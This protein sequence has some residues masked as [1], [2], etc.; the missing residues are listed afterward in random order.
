MST[1]AGTAPASL[2]LD[3][4]SVVTSSPTAPGYGAVYNPVSWA[5]AV[6]VW[7]H[8]CF[9]TGQYLMLVSR[10]WYAAHPSSPGVYTSFSENTA[11]SWTFINAPTGSRGDVSNAVTYIPM[12][13]ALSSPT[14]VGAASRPP[15]YLYVLTT[16]TLS[17]SPAAVL[18]HFSL[19]AAGQ[20]TLRAEEILPTVSAGSST[21]T[22][23]RGLHLDGPH[24][25]VYGSDATG[26]LYRIRKPWGH[27]GVNADLN[28][29]PQVL[30]GVVG[31]PAG[32]EYYT[33]SGYSAS[34][35][36]C[37]PLVGLDDSTNTTPRTPLTT[38][39]PLSFATVSGVTM[40]S[41]VSQQNGQA[42]AHLWTSRAGRP[43]APMNWGQS[44]GTVGGSYVGGGLGMQP[45]LHPT[46]P[47]VVPC[48][49][50][51]RAASTTLQTSW[52]SIS[53]TAAPVRGIPTTA[54]ITV[55]G[56]NHNQLVTLATPPGA[57]ITVAG[58]VV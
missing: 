32:W 8:P 10:R 41:T 1:V 6:P 53:P 37:A 29:T 56:G 12:T 39:G 45:L 52:L 9:Q 44:L 40:M 20:I 24:V 55:T 3:G 58:H 36:E 57:R 23:G 49:I 28:P 25:V 2:D 26:T 30:L 17:G 22:F 43:L 4:L 54:T 35:A 18:Q 33:G 19:S 48:V 7:F 16:G 31:S 11:P 14:L 5:A 47:A 27:V 50:S 21:V 13:T 42:T 34:V 46:N 38:T 15:A 51:L